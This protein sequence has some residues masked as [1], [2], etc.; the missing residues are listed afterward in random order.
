M[1]TKEQVFGVL[2]AASGPMSR[3]EL[4]EKVGESY[5]TFQSQLDRWIKQGLIE[6]TGDHHY[7]LTEEGREESLKVGEFKDIDDEVAKEPGFV[8]KPSGK[9]SDIAK[10]EPGLAGDEEP[11]QESLATTEYQQFL[12]LGKTTG[13]IPLALIKQ[14]AD[15]IWEGGDFRDMRWVAQAMKDMDIRQD[16][17]SR[18]W[19]SWRVKMHKAIPEDLPS[20]FLPSESKKTEET[21]EAAKKMGAGKREYILSE[22]DTPTYVGEGL[23]DLDYKDALELSK[24]R[25]VRGKGDGHPASAGSMADEVAKI[26]SAFKEVMGD[27]AAGKSYVVKPGAEGYQVEEVDTN[28]PLFITQPEAAKPSSSYY[29]DSDGSVKEL[30]P[31]QPVVIMKEPLKSAT[32]SG[33]QYL[34][35][36]RT[37]E[38]KQVEPGQPIVIIHESAPMSQSTPIQ[39]TDR[40]GK[41]LVLDLSTF[42]KLEEHR[43]KQRRDEESHQTKVEIAQGFKDMLKKAGTALSHVIES[44]E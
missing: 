26:F 34:I 43:D 20:E 4:E 11:S 29:V 36:K 17:R 10:R 39:V 7:V 8:S 32:P 14:T 23:G 44:E 16:L 13:V 38:V 6:D 40:D 24:L 1:A 5:R 37:G 33:T 35:D 3:A 12:K 2:A 25:I 41:P 30:L 22:D 28:K 27:R 31:G 19:G 15:Y 42:I 18:W 21:T 9:Q